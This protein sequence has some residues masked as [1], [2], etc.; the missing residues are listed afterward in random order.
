MAP[1]TAGCLV[2]STATE[3]CCSACR[4]AG[5]ELRFC[6]A[7]CQKRVWKYHKRICGPRSNP[8]LWP[9]L[10][11]EEAD[12]ALAHLDW[13]VQD[14]DH[15]DF[16]SLAMHFND[17]FS[18]PRDKLKN[19]VIPNLTE[20]RQAEF[21][22]TEPLDIAL[23]DL[24]TGE[25]RA[26]EMQR[27]DDIQMRT[28]QPRSTVWQYAS[29]QCQPL[30]R[31]PPP[32]MLEPWQSQLRHRIVVICALRKVQ[33]ANRSFYIRTACK[34]FTDWVAGDLAKEQPAAAAEVKERL[35]NFLMLCSLEQNGPANA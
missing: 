24:V 11:Q 14:P 20:A 19:N 15:P 28:M 23:T 9:P 16:P 18:T 10:T 22:R 17:R 13:R 4:K 29:M 32:Q 12:D 25:L 7:E 31:L 21:P 2:C 30:T 3:N 33:D 26:L 6:S 8:C 35:L 5:I 34:S 1:G 27:M